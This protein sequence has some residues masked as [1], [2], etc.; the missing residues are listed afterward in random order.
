WDDRIRITI[1]RAPNREVS[2]SLRIPAWAHNAKVAIN[3][4]A[5]PSI[6]RAGS[7]YELRRTWSAGDVVE[8]HLPMPVRILE[9]N[10]YVEETRNQVAVMR[11]PIV[12]CL[13]S[14]DL[15]EGVGI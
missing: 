13:E 8:L 12:Y 4:R 15:P 9:A 3:G 5:E 11:G 10:P 2:I 7:F 1:D 14:T 6:P